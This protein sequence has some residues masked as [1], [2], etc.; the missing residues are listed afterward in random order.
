MGSIVSDDLSKVAFAVVPDFYKLASDSAD[1]APSIQRVVTALCAA[2]GGDIKLLPRH[3]A[4]NSG[5]TIPCAVN[6][7]G[8]GWQETS[9][10]PATA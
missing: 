2:K 9:L 5:V 10:N 6:I 8:Q 7:I 1:D 4:I 3:Y